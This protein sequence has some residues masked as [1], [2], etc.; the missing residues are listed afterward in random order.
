MKLFKLELKT[1]NAERPTLNVEVIKKDK[2]NLLN[3]TIKAITPQNATMRAKAKTRLDQLTMPHWALGRLMDMALD[4]AGQTGTITPDLTKKAIVVMAGDHGVVAEGV[5]KYPQD[6]TWQMVANF[7]NCG[8]GINALAS[9]AGA[10]VIVVDMGV[11]SGLDEMARSGAILSMPVAKG[12]GNIAKGPAMSREQ[13]VQA[14]ESG[15]TIAQQL[16]LEKGYAVLGVGEMGIGNTTPS[17]AMI[18]ALTGKP[19]ASVTGT[20]TGL[21]N[22]ELL[23]KI[24]VIEQAL[25]V[26]AANPADAL[27][28]LAKL[29]GFEIGG[30]AGVILG[31]AALRKTVI[32]DGLIT[33]A[34]AMIAA[35]LCP[36]SVE[37]IFAAHK[38]VE[39]GHIVALA[40][41]GK[42][43]LL[44]LD[45]RLGEGTG[46]A[47]AMNLID[48][49][50]AVL[51]QVKTFEEAMVSEG[52]SVI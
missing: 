26:N 1:L 30:I 8:A 41:L 5:S 46:A 21:N 48:A 37:F 11:I 47:V 40:Q 35:A 31:A 25:K 20:G 10:D 13:A 12:T 18:A 33:T 7:V 6:V 42:A 29:G 24:A 4:L 23:H 15:I 51:T 50:V 27:D 9:Q 32:I 14:I 28:V 36:T 16:I 19:V 45:F 22:D 44:D 2:M 34:G 52:A 38:S 43:P 3:E 49:A 17:S 39:Q